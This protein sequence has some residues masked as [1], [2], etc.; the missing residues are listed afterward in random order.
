MVPVLQSDAVPQS[1]LIG[2]V[3]L[4]AGVAA[5]SVITVPPDPSLA[6]ETCAP[7]RLVAETN[8]SALPPL[9]VTVRVL[10]LIEAVAEAAVARSI[11]LP[12][13]NPVA[14]SVAAVLLSSFRVAPAPF[15]AIVLAPA[16]VPLASSSVSP[17]SICNR[18]LPA[19]LPVSFN[20]P[21]AASTVPLLVNARPMVLVLVPPVLA[22]VPAL[23]RIALVPLTMLPSSA[24]KS[25]L[26]PP[27]MARATVPLPLPS[28]RLPL[29]RMAPVSVQVPP[30]TN[31]RS[32]PLPPSRIA[33]VPAVVHALPNPSC[34]V[35]LPVPP[36]VPDSVPPFC[37]SKV[38]DDAR[39][40]PVLFRAASKTNALVAVS[41]SRP[42]L[43]KTGCAVLDGENAVT[44]PVPVRS[45]VPVTWLLTANVTPAAELMPS[46][47]AP[48]SCTSP[49]LVQLRPPSI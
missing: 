3:Q 11:R 6:V 24:V 29:S 14:A 17:A 31:C 35:P 37:N 43:A 46:L 19:T 48:D 45:K 28:N 40:V 13:P 44:P 15:K 26:A 36:I 30:L 23:V 32:L 21:L 27:V 7:V 12:T 1:P 47:M 20:V 9:G 16:I 41:S 4:T 2:K 25:K 10:P 33:S 5:P 39:T 22:R 49:L 18:P 42:A 38:P 8:L 34:N